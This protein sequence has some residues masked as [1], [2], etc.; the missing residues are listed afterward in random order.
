M[1][2]K[3]KII[4]KKKKAK[5]HDSHHGG[6]WKVAYADFVTAMMAF[7]LLMWL[8]NATSEEQRRGLS[9]YFGPSGNLTGMG[10]SGGVLAGLTLKSEGLLDDNATSGAGESDGK[11]YGKKT[12]NNIEKADALEEKEPGVLS[13]SIDSEESI[14]N[15]DDIL[16]DAEKSIELLDED[17]FKSA[18]EELHKAIHENEELKSLSKNLI[19]D[20]TENGLRI[21]I[22]DQHK[23]PMFAVGDVQPNE[24]AI[25]LFRSI[26]NIIKKMP[27]KISITGHTDSKLFRKRENYSNWELSTDRANSARRYLVKFGLA[28]DRVIYVTGKADREPILKH[29][30]SADINRRISIMLHKTAV[31]KQ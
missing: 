3:T 17:N 21:Q 13:D 22:V 15:D 14:Y 8:L 12:V 24:S 5:S 16:R 20:K 2:D 31:P 4:V 1:S 7:F 23:K 6:A 28:F 10:G 26:T 27:N 19:I 9:N 25:K 11:Y 29:N 30:T 18:E